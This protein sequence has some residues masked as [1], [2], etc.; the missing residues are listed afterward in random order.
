[1]HELNI[2]VGRSTGKQVLGAVLE[3]F[4]FPDGNHTDHILAQRRPG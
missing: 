1:M 2:D 3:D 4:R